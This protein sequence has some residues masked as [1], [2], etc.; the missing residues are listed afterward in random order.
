MAALSRLSKPSSKFFANITRSVYFYSSASAAPEPEIKSYFQNHNFARKA[1]KDRN[2]QWVF[3]GCPGVGKGTYASRLSKFLGV[4]HIATGDLVREELASSGSLSQQLSEI[5]NQGKLVS[6]EII[7]NLLSK[8]LEAGQAGGESGFILDGFPRTVK[9]AE[10]LEEVM[11]ID[12]V[13]N[14]KLCEDVL[15]EK[16]LGRRMCSQCGGNFNVAN[17]NVKGGNGNPSISMAP[18]LPPA[19]CMSKLITRPDDT[20]EVVKERLRVYNEKSQPVE[21]FYRNRGKLLEFDLPGGIPESWP[22]LLEAL[23]LDEYEEKQSA[24]A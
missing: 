6:D 7:F 2:V 9:Q 21:E 20:E 4:P 18:L 11:D 1:P 8:R 24:A 13:V 22:K 15:L 16:C 10:I 17:I 19:H 12:L 5:V 23:N 3:L 14:L